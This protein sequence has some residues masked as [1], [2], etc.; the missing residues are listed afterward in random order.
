[1]KE[2]ITF[3]TKAA[4]IYI[5]VFVFWKRTHWLPRVKNLERQSTRGRILLSNNFELLHAHNLYILSRRGWCLVAVSNGFEWCCTL[6][7]VQG[8]SELFSTEVYHSFTRCFGSQRFF[9]GISGKPFL[10]LEQHCMW[11]DW[12]AK[13]TSDRKLREHYWC[14]GAQQWY[15]ANHMFISGETHCRGVTVLLSCNGQ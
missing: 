8:P 12:H 7:N 2:L 15:F 3:D 14:F 9:Y 5:R 10:Y 6:H 13:P 1:M 11:S 4:N